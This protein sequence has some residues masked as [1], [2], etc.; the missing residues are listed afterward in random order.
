[1]PALV[2]LLCTLCSV[3]ADDRDW[4]AGWLLRPLTNFSSTQTYTIYFPRLAAPLLGLL[5]S[6]PPAL[7][8]RDSS[9]LVLKH[10]LATCLYFNA[11]FGICDVK[12]FK[13]ILALF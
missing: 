7:Q 9:F 13:K 4:L 10:V 2:G 12:N 8:V 6:G 3:G 1:M 11:T 5:E